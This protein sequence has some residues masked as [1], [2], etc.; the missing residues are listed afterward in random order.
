[1]TKEMEQELCQTDIYKDWAARIKRFSMFSFQ[2]GAARN[3]IRS[4]TICLVLI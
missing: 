1:M 2:T 3:F 4:G